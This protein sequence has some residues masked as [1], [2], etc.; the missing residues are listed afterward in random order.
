MHFLRSK[1]EISSVRCK[2]TRVSATPTPQLTLLSVFQNIFAQFQYSS[3]KV[4][5]SDTLRSA[6]AKTFQG[7]RR[8]QLGIMDDAAECFVRVAA[9][10][11][12]V[13]VLILMI[14]SV[15]A[16]EHSDEDSLPHGR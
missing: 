1:G 5:L 4:L 7:E 16:G 12:S 3:E 13:S 14:T 15:S 9:R 10:A 6:L 2:H 8:F 11:D